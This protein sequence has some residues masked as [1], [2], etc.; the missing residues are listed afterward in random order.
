MPV[1]SGGSTPVPRSP[2]SPWAEGFAHPLQALDGS[3]TPSSPY[4]GSPSAVPSS[5]RL[6]ATLAAGCVSSPLSPSV[7]GSPASTPVPTH[8]SGAGPYSPSLLHAAMSPAGSAASASAGLYASSQP[9]LVAPVAPNRLSSPMQHPV[10]GGAAAGVVGTAGAGVGPFGS[11]SPAYDAPGPLRRWGLEPTAVSPSS[12]STPP[13]PVAGPSGHGAGP[14]LGRSPMLH[15]GQ[16]SSGGPAPP[17]ARRLST[18]GASSAARPSPLRTELAVLGVPQGRVDEELVATAEAMGFTRAEVLSAVHAVVAAGHSA[19]DANFLLDYLTALRPP[20]N[21][22]TRVRAAHG[23]SPERADTYTVDVRAPSRHAADVWDEDPTQPDTP[24]AHVSPLAPS[25]PPLHLDASLDSRLGAPA[26]V[27][28][29][30]ASPR[31]QAPSPR[32][33]SLLG[34]LAQRERKIEEL[35]SIVSNLERNLVCKV[36]EDS[37]VEAAFQPCGHLV[38]C[39]RCCEELVATGHKTCIMCRGEWTAFVRVYLG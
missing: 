22:G 4:R 6:M 33:H 36:C 37:S 13:L 7:A 5:G 27:P 16:A 39:M 32:L 29:A 23:W 14:V 35:T 2:A 19:T 18:H 17:A 20:S 30:A 12:P 9:H 15:T 1:G 8:S 25:A 38:C 31:T 34:T 3:P 21:R 11:S 26:S 10:E 24:H 28:G